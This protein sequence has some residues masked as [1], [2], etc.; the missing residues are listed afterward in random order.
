LLVPIAKTAPF[1]PHLARVALA[2]VVGGLGMSVLACSSIVL[3]YG[4]DRVVFLLHYNVLERR[5]QRL[6]PEAVVTLQLLRILA[7]MTKHPAAWGT[8]E[9]K[10]ELVARL[11][12]IAG[13]L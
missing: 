8:L 11:E 6:Y 1:S 12:R 3:M 4:F 13:C 9:M 7:K 2:G 5:R 10:H